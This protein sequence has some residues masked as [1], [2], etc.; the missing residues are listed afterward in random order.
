VADKRAKRAIGDAAEQRALSYLEARGLRVVQR[1][2]RCRF[3]EIDLIMEDLDCLVVVEVRYRS[4]NRFATAAATVG[5]AKQGKLVRSASLFTAW[6]RRFANAPI[7]F[8]IIAIDAVAGGEG[9]VRWLR[10]AFRA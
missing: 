2:F 1:N 10:D 8:D 4:A 9:T 6:N 3:G 5:P 7:R